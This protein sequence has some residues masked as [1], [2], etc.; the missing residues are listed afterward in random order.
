MALLKHVIFNCS[1]VLQPERIVK[2]AFVLILVLLVGC[3][4]TVLVKEGIT[5]AEYLRDREECDNKAYQSIGRAP[6]WDDKINLTRWKRA[7]RAAYY[8][9]MYDKGYVSQQ[10]HT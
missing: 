10:L 3:T 1:A 5:E 2:I 9:C 4:S 7:L 6:S 8:Q